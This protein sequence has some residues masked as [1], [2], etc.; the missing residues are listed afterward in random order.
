MQI[1]RL[2]NAEDQILQAAAKNEIVT[3]S[4]RADS[5]WEPYSNF[6]FWFPEEKKNSFDFLLV[7]MEFFEACIPDIQIQ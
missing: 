4:G 5:K 3:F 1:D 7:F 2:D 6:V